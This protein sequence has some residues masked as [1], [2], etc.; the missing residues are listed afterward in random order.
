MSGPRRKPRGPRSG[1]GS[2]GRRPSRGGGGGRSNAAA[3]PI[4]LPHVKVTIRNI[5]GNNHNSVEGVV[6]SIKQFLEGAFN[7]S[8]DGSV[9]ED[10]PYMLAW[11]KEKDEFEKNKA[12]FEST[13]NP[14]SISAGSTPLSLGWTYEEKITDVSP[15]PSA[16]AIANSVERTMLDSGKKN[17]QSTIDTAMTT[18][19]NECG[20]LYL[21]YVGGKVVF[22]EESA[23]AVILAEKIVGERKKMEEAKAKAAVEETVAAENATEDEVTKEDKSVQEV[24]ASLEKLNTESKPTDAQAATATRIRIL[25]VTPVKKSKRRGDIGGR[26]E[27]VIYPPDPCLIFKEGCREAG[28]IAAERFLAAS[29]EEVGEAEA[30]ENGA[31]SEAKESEKVADVKT[32]A[33]ESDP[34]NM[35]PIPN[36]PR[37]SP[38][39]RSRAIARSRILMNRTIEAMKI[40]AKSKSTNFASWE[41]FESTSQK[42]WKGQS[43]PMVSALLSGASL[44]DLLA[45]EDSKDRKVARGYSRADRYDS[46]IENSDDY[47]TFMEK[48]KNG[49]FVPVNLDKDTKAAKPNEEKVDEEGRP[50]SAIVQHL[51]SKR[52]EEAKAKAEKAA[53]ASK[54]RAAASAAAAREKARKKELEAKTRKAK[55]RMA[56]G[57]EKKK[58]ANGGRSG[59][60]SRPGSASSGGA[61]PPPGAVL[62]KKSAGSVSIPASGF[63]SK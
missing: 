34:S 30:T 48:W 6:D 32:D 59:A 58:R 11:Q 40:H 31:V 53:A 21:N 47:K 38:A 16:A 45:E 2:A 49:G 55:A 51:Q 3:S 12:M 14:N 1:R 50:L 15:L 52:Q 28:T 4:Q 5:S 8:G 44:S 54:A 18:M 27:L 62:L 20:K 42:T 22:D 41:I 7:L 56:R 23:I 43:Q 26:V 61:A 13:S 33:R 29:K 57:E 24:T 35:P 60:S 37:L 10:S 46:T 39:E 36:F 9:L 17:I 25:S 19:M 63:N